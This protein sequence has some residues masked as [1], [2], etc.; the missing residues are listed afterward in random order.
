MSVVAWDG[1]QLAAD[2]AGTA[3]N[4]AVNRVAKIAA[5]EVPCPRPWIGHPPLVLIGVAGHPQGLQLA[6]DFLVGRTDELEL[7]TD[8][9]FSEVLMCSESGSWLW[10]GSRPTQLIIGAKAA[11]GSGAQAALALMLNGVGA[12][13]AVEIATVVCTYCEGPVQAFSLPVV[14]VDEVEP[15]VIH[16]VQ[17]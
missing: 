2:S 6:A 9:D 15:P 14:E 12:V 5:V 3:A 1:M 16:E 13:R 11:I 8:D 17:Q 10:S 4:G 7:G